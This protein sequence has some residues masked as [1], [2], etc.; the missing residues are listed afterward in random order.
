MFK[1]SRLN[2]LNALELQ[3]D[4]GRTSSYY[5]SGA[6]GLQFRSTGHLETS[7]GEEI[8]AELVIYDYNDTS[9][10]TIRDRESQSNPDD[11]VSAG[12][13][14]VISIDNYNA[15]LRLAD[16]DND[17]MPDDCGS[18]C[19]ILNLSSDTDDD[20][21]GITD[22][23][24]V[25]PLVA[26]SDLTDTD[27]DGAPDSCEEACVALGMAA[28][29]DDDNDGALDLDDAFPLDAKDYLDSDNDGLGDNYELDN[30]LSI[31]NPDFD[32]DG[33]KDGAE[34]KLGTNPKIA[35]TDDDGIKDGAE[36]KLGTNPKI[37]DTDDDGVIDGIDR[38]PLISIGSLLD[39]DND[40]APDSCD[41]ICLV[42][43][44]AEDLDDDNDGIVDYK[45]KFPS[46]SIGELLDFDGDG[47]PFICNKECLN[48]GMT[49]DADDQP[50]SM[51]DAIELMPF[52][53]LPA[54]IDGITDHDVYKISISRK[55]YIIINLDCNGIKV[56][57]KITYTT[58][59]YSF[60]G[61][62]GYCS[63][64]E[65]F[66]ADPGAHFLDVYWNQYEE[67][68]NYNISFKTGLISREFNLDN[69]T[70][71]TKHFSCEGS[72]YV[73]LPL[74]ASGMRFAIKPNPGFGLSEWRGACNGYSA[75][76]ISSISDDFDLSAVIEPQIQDVTPDYY[77]IDTN[78]MCVLSDSGLACYDN[79]GTD[80]TA[81]PVL[82]N[83]KTFVS[84][85]EQTCAVD[86]Y[87]LK[88]WG[89]NTSNLTNPPFTNIKR[90]L[91]IAASSYSICAITD[92][93]VL[94]WPS[95]ND[96][97][98]SHPVP[99][100]NNPTKLFAG[101][102]HFCAVDNNGFQCWGESVTN[103]PS[104]INFPEAYAAGLNHACVVEDGRVICWGDNS[105][106]Q[107]NIPELDNVSTITAGW[108][109]TCAISQNKIIC[110]GDNSQGQ[111]NVPLNYSKAYLID[112]FFNG[113]CAITK[114]GNFCWSVN[115]GRYK[116]KWPRGINFN[117]LNFNYLIPE[118]TYYDSS[119]EFEKL[120]A[121]A[122]V[123]VTSSEGDNF[124]DIAKY[125]DKVS[126]VGQTFLVSGSNDVDGFMIQPGVKY[127][128]TN[129]KGSVDKLYFS[130]T[131]A[132]YA[133]SILIDSNTGV[134]QLS[135]L[136]DIGEE[137][138]Q[139]IATNSA[140]DK[141]VFID[142]SL[143]AESVKEALLQD[144]TITTLALDETERTLDAKTVTG[145]Q[146][147]HIVLDNEGAG[148][149][150]LGPK[151]KQLISGS[152]GVDKIYVPA[153]S[154]VDASNLKANQ[155]K[156][157]LEGDLD[158]YTLSYNSSSNIVLS[159][160]VVIDDETFTES[161]TVA[162]GGNVA[163]N[164]LLIFLDQ[165]IDTSTLKSQVSN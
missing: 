62:W 118:Y 143:S 43:G 14:L 45:D 60:G 87:G 102:H 152:S 47:A 74:G 137:I 50:D 82:T 160:D 165:Q 93:E 8:W 156:V 164:D 56:D 71:W 51:N 52:K 9:F 65:T 119:P 157:Y 59:E 75:S 19:S 35:D 151:I 44:M 122:K 127:D 162:N 149:M 25:Y 97:V 72:C 42:L 63:E 153:G 95:T 96:N 155:D 61:G 110:W 53:I 139:F 98:S 73:D 27:A 55:T 32:A 11:S 20:N 154:V 150:A 36:I 92:G 86:D 136:T 69:G 133:K 113:T 16:S 79:A 125:V 21:D 145:G 90:P 81:I 161:V 158:D 28:D 141:L 146:V 13:W 18:S 24:D 134:M 117:K 105:Y 64:E 120:V 111:L 10:L 4:I 148:V 129:L 123:I 23:E 163:T 159:R 38:F 112:A 115:Y 132:E 26:I 57:A 101:R 140:A 88:C 124:F 108:N 94:C 17:G 76:C 126:V 15:R 130:G 100:L 29:S 6:Q 66:L 2:K 116:N 109:H 67:M 46:V 128:L 1:S 131:F 138:V 89:G 106:G 147:K 91:S 39:T 135:R 49:Q 41:E 12:A 54:R 144:I 84:S 85:G 83:V 121:T 7:V 103:V 37:A 30:G 48:L 80:I 78:G 58:P 114:E 142:G 70:L 3:E 40:G 107:L 34:I 104:V 33:I 99:T 22:T 31:S 5:N 68:G 77:K